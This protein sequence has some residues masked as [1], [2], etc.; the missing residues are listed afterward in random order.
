M[1]K[2]CRLQGTPASS[3]LEYSGAPPPK[4]LPRPA[5]TPP[6]PCE[7]LSMAV[8][9]SRGHLAKT[10]AR[11]GAASRADLANVSETLAMSQNSKSKTN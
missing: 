1:V 5:L 3:V 4:R 9:D 6:D 10:G 7:L 11:W 8:K 2:S